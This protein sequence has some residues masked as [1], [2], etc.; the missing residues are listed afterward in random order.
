MSVQLQGGKFWCV[1][2]YKNVDGKRKQVWYRPGPCGFEN[3]R[4]GAELFEAKLKIERAKG[5]FCEPTII[6]L[7]EYADR[8]MEVYVKRKCQPNTVDS[9]EYHLRVHIKPAL[10]SKR[11][12]NIRP[13]DIEDFYATIKRQDGKGELSAQTKRDTHRVLNALFNHAVEMEV[14]ARNP[15]KRRLIPKLE[16]IKRQCYTKEQVLQLLRA[17]EE[18]PTTSL[19]VPVFIAYHTGMRI[20][21]IC[22]LKWTDI[23]GNRITICRNMEQTKGV[24]EKCT[25]NGK[26]RTIDI[27]SELVRM[28]TRHKGEQAQ[29]RL[30]TSGWKDN[31]YVW[32]NNDGTA[33]RPEAS[34]QMFQKF[35]KEQTDLPYY[36]F[37]SLRHT[38][39]SMLIKDGWHPK[40]IQDRVGHS[41][42]T[43]TMDVYGHL[44]ET[45]K[46]MVDRLDKALGS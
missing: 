3:T 33:R 26:E 42:I 2:E 28:L 27:S 22:A 41:S 38:H 24:R 11:L 6:T 36:S 35:I 1:V 25:K 13:V 18:S 39:V 32:P 23:D 12:M 14:I 34:S 30:R 45:G 9:Y 10:G 17:L 20:G 21:E 46:E 19:Y 43:M 37:H 31:G 29:I 7:S 40:E 8:W 5:T 44:F 16:K 4:K 15:I